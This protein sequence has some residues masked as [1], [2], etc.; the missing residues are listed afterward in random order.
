MSVSN[1]PHAKPIPAQKMHK[2]VL[3]LMG[4]FTLLAVTYPIAM[5]RVSDME[6][7][8]GFHVKSLTPEYQPAVS[9]LKTPQK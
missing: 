9:E 8:R 6:K 2:I 1:E 7:F 5:F 3:V 4:V